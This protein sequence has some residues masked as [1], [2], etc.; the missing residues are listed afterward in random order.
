MN[1]ISPTETPGHEAI[2]AS[3]AAPVDGTAIL[4]NV[5][6]ILP[7]VRAEADESDRLGRLTD[8]LNEAF[9]RA[10]IYRAGFSKARG[11]P[12]MPL[13]QQTRM[14]ELVAT[15]DGACAWNVAVL[16]ATGFYA[17]RLGDDAFAALYPHLDLP[18]AGSFNPRGRTEKVEG[19]YRVSGT[20][21]FGSGIHSAHYVL[22]GAEV[23]EGGQPVRKPDGSHLVLGLW[24]RVEDVEILDDWDVVGLSASGSSGYRVTDHFVPAS[25]TFDRHFAPNPAADPLN[26]LVELPFYSMAGIAAGL[27]QHAIDIATDYLRARPQVDERQYALLGEAQSLLRAVRATIYAGVRRIDEVLFEEGG[28]PSPRDMARGDAPVATELARRIVDLCTDIAG[29][30]IVYNAYPLGRVM[31]DLIG[32]S[33]HASTYRSR[34]IDIGK[35]YLEKSAQ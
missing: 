21:K 32:L 14:V 23:F 1:H 30:R 3:L 33:A 26:R 11:G 6:A 4:R 24:F 28:V 12:E 15:V 19:G 29:S 5:E 10:G 16:A 17:C 27:S 9:M 35:L 20:W 8:R 13:A 22:G 7:I 25:H 2:L 18:T 31:R 34:Y